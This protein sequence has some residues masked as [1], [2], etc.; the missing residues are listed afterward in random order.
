MGLNFRKFHK[1]EVVCKII[2]AEILTAWSWHIKQHAFA[3]LF[4]RNFKVGP[5]CRREFLIHVQMSHLLKN[6]TKYSGSF[7]YVAF[8]YITRAITYKLQWNC[9]VLLEPTDFQNLAY[10]IHVRLLMLNQF[11]VL[12]GTKEALQY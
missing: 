11:I 9:D 6:Q 12:C 2:S 7:I 10:N 4:Q 1:F 3:K 5:E 8:L